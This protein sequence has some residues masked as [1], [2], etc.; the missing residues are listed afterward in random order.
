[1][2]GGIFVGMDKNIMDGLNVVLEGQSSTYGTMISVII[3]SSFTLFILYRGYQTLGGKL[4]TPVEDVV[5]DVGR[6]LLITTFV[7]NLDGWL[8][9]A[10]AA[11]E[12]LKDGISGDDNIWALLDTVWEKAQTLGQTLFSMDTSTYVKLNGGFAEV[13]VWGGAIVLLMAATFA[14]LLA[15]ITIL[16]MTTT[17]PLFIFCLLYGFLKP[18]FDNWLKTIFAA[19]LTIMF[20]ALS[21]R[22]AIN[23]L[24]KILDTA[25]KTSAET[26]MVTLAAQCLLAGTAAGVVV[27]FS[28]KLASALS[29]AAVQA[30][31][32]GAVMSGLG[33]L[34]NKSADLAGPGIKGGARMAARG[35]MA[36]ATVAGRLI[37]AGAGKTVNAWQ[38]RAAAIESMKRLNRQRHR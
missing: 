12:G 9:M 28:A 29:G 31:L 20:S 25:A 10:I 23:Y 2:S 27:W 18:M 37:S 4:R 11:I 15:E 7:L 8:D 5:W 6:M 36:A 30:V 26:N 32:Q 22:I 13:L 38:K 35:G 17:A 3:V 16:L 14:N 34:A 19:I 24:N 1:M 21:I 33:G